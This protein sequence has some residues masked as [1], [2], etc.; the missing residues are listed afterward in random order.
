[1]GGQVLECGCHVGRVDIGEIFVRIGCGGCALSFYVCQSD[2]RGQIYCD[3]GCQRGAAR[4]A[5]ARHQRSRSGRFDHA[6]RN[7][8]YRLR[9]AALRE[10]TKIVTDTRSNN[11]AAEASSCMR[12]DAYSSTVEEHVVAPES[13]EDGTEQM[14]NA[15]SGASDAAVDSGEIRREVGSL[16]SG[17]AASVARRSAHSGLGGSGV[18]ADDICCVV[19]GRRGR[20]IRDAEVRPATRIRSNDHGRRR[21]ARIARPP[22][23]P[24]RSRVR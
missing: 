18:P 12:G 19:C 8:A 14:D 7:V 1:M 23:G 20:F 3:P 10:Q 9:Q 6:A 4:A 21:R 5:R 2:Y 16:G 15:A 22:S 24:P 17:A 13:T 11:L